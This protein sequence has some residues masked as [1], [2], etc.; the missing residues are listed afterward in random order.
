MQTA[1][2]EGV[3]I[4]VVVLAEGSWTMEEPNE[5]DL[6]G[7]TFGTRQGEIRWDLVAEGLGCHAEHVDKIEDLDSALRRAQSTDGPSLVCIRSD[8]DANL[9]VPEAMVARFFEVYSGPVEK[10]A[11][12]PVPTPA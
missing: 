8:H 4:T 2:R 10:E 6:Y 11:E 1:A 5:L 12:A 3:A 9:A 7:R